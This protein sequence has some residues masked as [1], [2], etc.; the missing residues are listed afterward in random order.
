MQIFN[1]CDNVAP[2]LGTTNLLLLTISELLETHPIFKAG[3]SG[4]GAG[5]ERGGG[6]G[7]W[8]EHFGY[9]G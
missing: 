5:G 8:A 2:G 1:R 3:G 4:G 6:S 7:G 9:A